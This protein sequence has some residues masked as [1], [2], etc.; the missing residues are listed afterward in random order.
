MIAEGDVL[1]FDLDGTLVKSNVF[2]DACYVQALREVLGHSNF[3]TNWET[4]QH[5]TD[6]GLLY[7]LLLNL[8]VD[9]PQSIIK[10]VR[11]VFGE[12]IKHY[13]NNGGACVPIPGA[14][15]S[16]SQLVSSGFKV[17]IATGGWGHTARMKLRHA[18]FNEPEF[19]SSCDDAMDRPGI[20]L[21]CCKMLG[22]DP[23]RAIYFGDASWD[24]KATKALGWRFIGV[25]EHFSGV[26][27][28]WI[29]NFDD[30]KWPLSSNNTIKRNRTK[31]APL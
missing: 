15:E 12:Q 24:V 13:L 31:A 18:G 26:C 22:G 21:H 6:T 8:G 2:D 5:V 7:E 29:S 30:P 1:I 11:G 9:E 20:M 3:N 19:L 25:G 23:G 28:E 17:G 4:Y 27:T 14:I 10:R 16:I